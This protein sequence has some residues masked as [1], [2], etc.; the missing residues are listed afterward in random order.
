[1]TRRRPTAKTPHAHAA[2]PR[3][4]PAPDREHLA[5]AARVFRAAGDLARLRLLER[6]ADGACC[7]GELAE[8]FGVP[9][10]TISH[11]LRVLHD[12]GLVRRERDGKHVHYSVADQHVADLILNALAHAGEHH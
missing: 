1:M 9:M 6:L 8:A 10:P 11:Q 5:A 12:A 2:R 7:V 3:T 4:K